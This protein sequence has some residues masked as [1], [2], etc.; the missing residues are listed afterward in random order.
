MKYK[1]TETYTMH[2]KMQKSIQCD[3]QETPGENMKFVKG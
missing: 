3:R 2:H 1:R